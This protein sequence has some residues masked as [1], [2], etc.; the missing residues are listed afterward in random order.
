MTT[1]K[2]YTKDEKHTEDALRMLHYAMKDGLTKQN[3]DIILQDINMANNKKAIEL[4]KNVSIG[5]HL[6]KDQLSEIYWILKSGTS[7]GD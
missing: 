6:K 3:W 7:L 2:K 1:V 5:T 4:A